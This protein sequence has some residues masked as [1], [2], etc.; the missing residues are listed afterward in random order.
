MSDDA[1]RLA[2]IMFTDIVGYTAL[3]QADEARALRLLAEHNRLLREVFARFRGHEIKTVGDAFLVEF[4]SAL[5]A[6]QG[7]VEV[8]RVLEDRNG[9]VAEEDRLHVRIGVHV[10]DVVP[11]NGDLLGD[12]VNVA[13][14]IEPLA[15]PGGICLSQQVYDQ[16]HNKL[17][18]PLLRLPPRELKNVRGP[19]TVY[20]VARTWLSEPARPAEQA[21]MAGHHVAVLPLSNISP[22]P[23]D[24]YFADGLTEEL[25][26]VLSRVPDLGV[27]ARTSVMPY[28]TQ[29]KSI[30]EVGA[31]LGVETV[32]EGSV[33]KAGSHLRITLQLVD[34][35]TQRHIWANSYNRELTDVFAVQSDIAERTAEALRLQLAR[36]GGTAEPRRLTANPEAYDLYLRGLVAVTERDEQLDQAVDFFRRATELDPTFAEAYAAWANLYVAAAGDSVPMGEF[37]AKARTLVDRALELDPLS[38]EAH[39]ALGNIRFQ[40]GLDWEGAEAEFREALRLNP[41]NISAHQFLGLM[42]IALRRFGEAQELLRRGIR[43]DP[44]GRLHTTLDLALLWGGDPDGALARVDDE[45]GRNPSS[46]SLHLTRGMFAVAAGR[47]KEAEREA[48]VP[49]TGATDDLVFDHAVLAALLGRRT[50]AEAVA[51]RAERGELATYLSPT[52]FAIL[53][54]ALG[55]NARALDLLEQDFREGGRVLWLY[56]QGVW[57]DALRREPRFLALL[58]LYRLPEL[59]PPTTGSHG[60][61]SGK[62][63]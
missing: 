26:S 48:D 57:F 55:E 63:G 10:G 45:L 21:P 28:K 49:L 3:A 13:A 39:A 54:A 9:R 25:I 37:L 11:A 1:R 22:E 19:V 38:S 31:E 42:Y 24:A 27:I 46:V 35:A 62:A 5:D 56:Y 17:T 7:G 15:E 36:R 40:S 33:R 32:L 29:P 8:Q 41:S 58:R 59:P 61:A 43:L 20:R 2:A 53:Y 23:A 50:T 51:A 4:E 44:G 30:A 18:T 14:R 16:V 6:V 60:S 47:V 52:H 12:A 34:V